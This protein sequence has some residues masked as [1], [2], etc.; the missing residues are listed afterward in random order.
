MKT[1][2]FNRQST[3][4]IYNTTGRRGKTASKSTSKH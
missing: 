2:S 3:V 1:S 4:L